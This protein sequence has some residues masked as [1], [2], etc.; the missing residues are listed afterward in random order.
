MEAA[1]NRMGLE[2]LKCRAVALVTIKG[3]LFHIDQPA[4]SKTEVSFSSSRMTKKW[5]DYV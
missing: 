2:M 4:T 5:H 3:Q 1:K